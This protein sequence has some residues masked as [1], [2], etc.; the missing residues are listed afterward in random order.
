M[1]RFWRLGYGHL[2]GEGHYPAFRKNIRDRLLGKRHP[3]DSFPTLF[4][5]EEA[6][7]GAKELKSYC[8]INLEI[9]G[10]LVH[11]TFILL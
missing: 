4:E 10:S 7:G 11:S 2:C 3:R 5:S 1:H 9:S 6:I 8:S